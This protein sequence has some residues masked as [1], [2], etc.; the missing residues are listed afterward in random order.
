MRSWTTCG[1]V[2][3][4]LVAGCGETKPVT[5]T[6]TVTLDGKPVGVGNSGT[7][8]FQP[9]DPAVGRPAEGFINDGRYE[10]KV[11]P[12]R[13]DVLVGWEKWPDP[14]TTRGKKPPPGYDEIPPTQLI[15]DKYVK[16]GALTADVSA[17]KPRVDFPL[18]T[19]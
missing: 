19:K 16:A 2:V 4:L 9:A 13:Y 15:P 11:F 17:D 18:L 14:A 6:G 7:I 3:A 10:V 12:G 5:V 8:R 1:C